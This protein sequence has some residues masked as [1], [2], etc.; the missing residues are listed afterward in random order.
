V[1]GS[2]SRSPARESLVT[3]S[4]RQ[5]KKAFLTEKAEI[6]SYDPNVR[7]MLL[8]LKGIIKE[9]DKLMAEIGDDS[10]TVEEVRDRIAEG[11]SATVNNEDVEPDIEIT[12]FSADGINPFKLNKNLYTTWVEQKRPVLY[13]EPSKRYAARLRH[14]SSEVK[15][16]FAERGIEIPEGAFVTEMIEVQTR[17]S[18]LDEMLARLFELFEEDDGDLKMEVD[19]ESRDTFG[20]VAQ[21]IKKGL[22]TFAVSDIRFGT[23]YNNGTDFIAFDPD[24]EVYPTWVEL[25][26]PKLYLDA[27]VYDESETH[28]IYLAPADT[29]MDGLLILFKDAGYDTDTGTGR[30]AAEIK[31]I[32]TT[33]VEEVKDLIAEIIDTRDTRNINLVIGNVTLDDE[34]PIYRWAKGG[35]VISIKFSNNALWDYH[36]KIF[37][38]AEKPGIQTTIHMLPASWDPYTL[39]LAGD[40]AF[41]F[42]VDADATIDTLKTL[43]AEK[44][45]VKKARIGIHGE[46]T[47]KAIR[48]WYRQQDPEKPLWFVVGPSK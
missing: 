40:N 28:S 9:G 38:R 39:A 17:T 32:S 42:V 3:S 34:D 45:D 23:P 19:P 6:N 31:V 10:G 7:T 46:D 15:K 41:Q 4:P 24:R 48:A 29:K 22:R 27:R 18:D 14:S 1:A 44:L 36:N 20:E 8:L 5:K 33:K 37:E 47:T 25:G 35:K 16:E 21:R 2:A 11:I 43:L 30:G 26:R 12:T 13:I